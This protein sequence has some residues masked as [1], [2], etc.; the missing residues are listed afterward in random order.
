MD[1]CC[2][3]CGYCPHCGRSHRT[4]PLYPYIVPMPQPYVP[5]LPYYTPAYPIWPNRGTGDPLP[6]WPVITCGGNS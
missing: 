6:P 4:A 3:H 1:E 2:P 5:M